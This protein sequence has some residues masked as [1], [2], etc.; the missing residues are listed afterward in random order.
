MIM[1]LASFAIVILLTC[2]ELPLLS[3]RFIAKKN[4]V[5]VK[6]QISTKYVSNFAGPSGRAV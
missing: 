1:K 2:R 5:N 3:E 6:C 4:Y